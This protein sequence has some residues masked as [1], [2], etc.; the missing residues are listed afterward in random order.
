M[1]IQ[2]YDYHVKTAKPLSSHTLNILSKV[3]KA[4]WI[5][6]LLCLYLIC[7]LGGYCAIS[8]ADN[9]IAGILLF[10]LPPIVFLIF[11]LELKIYEKDLANS[12]VTL[13]ESSVFVVE[14]RFGRRKESTIDLKDIHHAQVLHSQSWKIRGMRFPLSC[15]YRVYFDQNNRFLF[16]TTVTEQS[17]QWHEKLMQQKGFLLEEA[18]AKGD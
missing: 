1:K 2:T 6:G 10:I 7:C 14:Y 9:L 5:I 16:K 12:S 3:Q 4:C 18:V 11:R 8:I 15:F 17:T 13:E